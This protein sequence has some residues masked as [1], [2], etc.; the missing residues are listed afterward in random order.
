MAG[1]DDD[2]ACRMAHAYGE[3]CGRRGRQTDVD[4]IVAHAHEGTAYYILY[5]L[6]GDAGI[7]SDNDRV[8]L[9]VFAAAD[10]GGVG[11]C[12]LHNVEWVQRITCMAT[13][14]A[15]NTWK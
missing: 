9:R 1:G 5:H 14:G 8:A 2:A 15:A 13:N 3:L 10:E 6:S 12:E 4:D 7:A 11:R